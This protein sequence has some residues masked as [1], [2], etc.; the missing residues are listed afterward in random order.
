VNDTTKTTI[1]SSLSSSPTSCI[2]R[3]DDRITMVVLL[4]HRRSPQSATVP[5][6]CAICLSSY[7]AGEDIVWSSNKHC[8]HAYHQ[9]ECGRCRLL[10][11]LVCSSSSGGAM[12]DFR[13]HVLWNESCTPS[14]LSVVFLFHYQP[15]PHP[16]CS[17][18]YIDC[19][20]EYFVLLLEP[21]KEDSPCPC[22]RRNFCSLTTPTQ[23][24]SE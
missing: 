7:K 19:I 9:G 17:F 12:V 16:S 15:S 1:S 20:L 22:C 10:L 23:L 3:N 24:A 11:L 13:L 6:Q 14:A 8:D 4:P 5:N 21:T 18:C 2:S